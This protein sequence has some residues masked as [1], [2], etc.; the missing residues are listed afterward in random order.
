MK[1]GTPTF[2]QLQILATVVECDSFAAAGCR[3]NRATSAIAYVLI[4]GGRA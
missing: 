4:S 2:D 3:L 1:V